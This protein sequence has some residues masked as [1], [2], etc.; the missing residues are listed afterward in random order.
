[1]LGLS[2][3]VLSE[4]KEIAISPKDINKIYVVCHDNNHI[5]NS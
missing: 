1:M 4:S 5:S 2:N 3:I